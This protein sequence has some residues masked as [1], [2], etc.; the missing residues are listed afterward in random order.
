MDAPN[1]VARLTL[2]DLVVCRPGAVIEDE[3]RAC[4]AHGGCRRE[5]QHG[6]G[7][8]KGGRQQR[9]TGCRRHDGA[10]ADG[11]L[12]TTLANAA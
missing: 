1:N 10:A 11:S 8:T 2:G 4:P 12:E 6:A 9:G 3:S 5:N 7:L